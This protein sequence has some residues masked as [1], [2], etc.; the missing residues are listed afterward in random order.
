MRAART[1]ARGCATRGHRPTHEADLDARLLAQH[2]LGWDAAR[3]FRVGRR[4]EPP[5]TFATRLRAAASR[6]ARAASRSPTSSAG[7]EFWGLR[8]RGHAGGADPAA[9]NR[10]DRRGRAR[11]AFRT[12]RRPRDR[13]R[14]HRQRLPGGRDR[15]ERAGAAIVATDISHEALDVARRNASAPR[16]RRDACRLSH[17]DLLDG[18]AG[19]PFDSIVANPPYVP[20]GDRP[21]L[22]PEVRDY[23]PAVALF[24]GP[25]GCDVDPAARCRGAGRLAPGGYLIFEFGLGQDDA[26]EQLIVDDARSSRM[27]R[28]PANTTCRAFPTQRSWRQTRLADHD[29]LPVLQDHQPR[30]SGVDRLRGRASARL[31]RHQPAGADARARRPE[32]AHRVAERSRS[33]AT[34]GSSASRAARGGDREGAR[35]RGGGFRTVFNTNRDAGQTVFHIHLHL[36]GGRSMAWPPGRSRFVASGI[37]RTAHVRRRLDTTSL[38]RHARARVGRSRIRLDRQSSRCARMRRVAAVQQ[39][40]AHAGAPARPHILTHAVAHHHRLGRRARSPDRSAARKML[41]CGFIARAPTTRPRRR[42]TPRSSKCDWNDARQR[43][44]FE[45]S[46]IRRPA[47][48]SSRSAGATRRTARSAGRPPT[49]RRSRARRRRAAP[50]PAHLLDDVPRVADEDLGVVYAH[51]PAR[52]GAA[53]RWPLRVEPRRVDLHAV[54]RAERAGSPRPGTSGPG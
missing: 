38:T 10:A 20:P 8:V 42:S 14:L 17:G 24:A 46:P 40:G 27:R 53:P 44:E 19:D 33:P 29:R 43:C 48:A 4:A 1:R 6:A 35:H 18:V 3:F 41:G 11:A 52:R 47:A 22:Q 45:I 36:L 26:V 39:H 12:R 31:Q 25:T 37:S 51:L 2:V 7:Q 13:R 23:E 50:A 21:R 5:A 28:R 16:R 32:A 49:R 34:I 15:R 9:G 30:D 54:P